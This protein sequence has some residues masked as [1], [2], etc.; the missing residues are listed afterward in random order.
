MHRAPLERRRAQMVLVPVVGHDELRLAQSRRV[1]QR[2]RRPGGQP[3]RHRAVEGAARVAL[4]LGG[5]DAVEPPEALARQ[6]GAVAALPADEELRELRPLR[7]R[8]PPAR[9][10]VDRGLLPAG[11]EVDAARDD[12]HSGA[13]GA[14]RD[15]RLRGAAVA[16]VERERA[17]QA[18]D[19]LAHED[20][21][22]HAARHRAGRAPATE[23]VARRLERR[24]GMFG[25]AVGPAR[26][27]GGVDEEGVSFHAYGRGRAFTPWTAKRARCAARR[28]RKSA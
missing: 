6:A 2:A 26:R 8:A 22:R 24:E 23:G 14:P 28:S 21:D 3:R 4:R 25:G 10:A 17:L 20:V 13:R 12:G 15:R 1:A 19:P 18:V 9:E 11:R 5:R 7:H 16:S 27:R